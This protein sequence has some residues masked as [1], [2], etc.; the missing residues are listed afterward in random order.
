MMY[1]AVYKPHIANIYTPKKMQT[2]Q[3]IEN[4]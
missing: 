3:W 4:Y 2:C 1:R